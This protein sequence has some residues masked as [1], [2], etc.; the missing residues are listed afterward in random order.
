MWGKFLS[1]GLAGVSS[2]VPLAHAVDTSVDSVGSPQVVLVGSNQS[3]FYPGTGE[4]VVS[5]LESRGVDVS[6]YRDES[7]RKV[8][9]SEV[10]KP[11]EVRMLYRASGDTVH[12]SE[13]KLSHG[14]SE[15]SSD[16]VDEGVR[17][18]RHEGSDGVAKR[19]EVAPGKSDVF[20]VKAPRPTVVE[21]GTRKK[22]QPAAPPTSASTSPSPSPSASQSPVSVLPGDLPNHCSASFYDEDE[23]T[24]TGEKFE[25]DGMTA[26]HKTLP[27]GSHIRVK[28]MRTGKS[29][30]LRVNDRGPYVPGR[31]LDLSRGAFAAIDSLG[32]GTTDVAWEVLK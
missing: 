15:V 3:T 2:V 12:T 4:S 26:A 20:V 8:S 25:P 11:G 27:L 23:V 21:V 17:R 29:V 14:V 30:V 10:A 19:V 24:A 7:G 9:A 16:R 1:I 13:V 22:P 32:A 28:S 5:Y 6:L 18:V 31:C